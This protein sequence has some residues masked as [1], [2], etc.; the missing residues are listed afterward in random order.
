M[1]FPFLS[2]CSVL[3]LLIAGCG[4]DDGSD[5]NAGGGGAAGRVPPWGS[6][7]HSG[8]A[9]PENRAGGFLLY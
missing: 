3:G 9:R 2:L 8:G 4:S 7:L 5:G 6:A 1:R